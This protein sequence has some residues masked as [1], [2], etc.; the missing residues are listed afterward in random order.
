VPDV[1]LLSAA[2]WSLTARLSIYFALCSGALIAAMGYVLYREHVRGFR[3]EHKRGTATRYVVYSSP[4]IVGI[5]WAGCW[6]G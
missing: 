3:E 1:R 2:G 6:I 4:S 5:R